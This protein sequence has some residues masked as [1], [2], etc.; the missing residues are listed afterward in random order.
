MDY[1]LKAKTKKDIFDKLLEIGVCSQYEVKN[2]EG[3]VIETKYRLDNRFCLDDIGTV[4]KPT[5]NMIR[6]SKGL[7]FP[8]LEAVDGY[9]V[10]LRGPD[11]F[12]NKVEFVPYELT[13]EDKNNPDFVLPPATSKI[14][15][16][17]LSDLLVYPK[18]PVRTWA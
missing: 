9:H 11:I 1:Y 5:G 10:N 3:E 13:E 4:Y 6:N 2:E 17:A 16:G 8:E 12:S 18:T 14:I 15:K 7:E